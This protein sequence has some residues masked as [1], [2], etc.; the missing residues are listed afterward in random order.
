MKWHHTVLGA[1]YQTTTKYGH[2]PLTRS[3]AQGYRVCFV[4]RGLYGRPTWDYE[5][6]V[7]YY[8]NMSVSSSWHCYQIRI[9]LHWY[10]NTT[11]DVTVTGC[12][13]F[14]G[15]PWIFWQGK[16]WSYIYQIISVLKKHGRFIDCH[17][18]YYSRTCHL[19]VVMTIVAIAT[20]VLVLSL[21]Y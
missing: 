15:E 5:M 3:R 20:I 9:N 12:N 10:V 18:K 17:I 11:M 14:T 21:S 7:N 6:V 16:L 13:T 4:S 2:K 19:F 1:T 8:R